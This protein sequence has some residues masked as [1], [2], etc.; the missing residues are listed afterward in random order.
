MWYLKKG[1]GG[2]TPASPAL[3]DMALKEKSACAKKSTVIRKVKSFWSVK[4][5][6]TLPA[7]DIGD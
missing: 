1:G 4:L 5:R 6:N 2:E 7:V 3:V